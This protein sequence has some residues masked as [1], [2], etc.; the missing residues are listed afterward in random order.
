MNVRDII[1][2]KDLEELHSIFEKDYQTKTNMEYIHFVSDFLC[3]ADELIQAYC[4]AKQK[5]IL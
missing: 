2:T 3:A 4:L 1:T 5:Q